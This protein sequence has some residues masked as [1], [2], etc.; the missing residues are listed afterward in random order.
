MYF[1][2]DG[3]SQYMVRVMSSGT[4][5][6]VVTFRSEKASN[7]DGGNVDNVVL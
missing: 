1:H 3:S 2:S 5:E 6:D 7:K 4:K